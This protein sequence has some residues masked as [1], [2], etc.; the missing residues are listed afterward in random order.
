MTEH[1]WKRAHDAL[2]AYHDV[3][4]RQHEVPEGALLVAWGAYIEALRAATNSDLERAL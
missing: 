2:K 1:P 4:K 3:R